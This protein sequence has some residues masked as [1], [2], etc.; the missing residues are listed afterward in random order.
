MSLPFAVCS[1]AGLHH[2]AIDWATRASAN[3]GVISTNTIRAV[4]AFCGAIDTAQIRDR[5]ARLGI[6]AGGNLSGALVPLYRSFSFGGTLIGNATDTNNN[7]VTGDY[8]DTG[9]SGGLTGNGTN[10][11]LLVGSVLSSVDRANSHS[12]AYGSSLTSPATGDRLLMGAESASGAGIVLMQT[13]DGGNIA[14]L[15][16]FSANSVTNWVDGAATTSGFIMGSAVSSTDL[17]AYVNGVQSGS[18]VTANRGTGAQTSR[19]MPVFAYNANGSIVGYSAARLSA[20]SVGL[21]MTAAQALA[22]NAAMQ[23]LQTA[24]GRT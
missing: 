6:F 20:Y 3:G 19:T 5:F 1:A 15:R 8:A 21:G 16:Y 7:F 9:A 18:T 13:R 24:L 2:E 17:R 12:A 14:R 22:Y 11:H 4:S 10:K 23:S